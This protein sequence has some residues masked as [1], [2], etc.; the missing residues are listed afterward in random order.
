MHCIV[1]H[2]I[3]FALHLQH[4][5]VGNAQAYAQTA[6]DGQFALAEGEQS[7]WHKL[8]QNV[9]GLCTCVFTHHSA[10]WCTHTSTQLCPHTPWCG[11]A[12]ALQAS[13]KVRSTPF[14]AGGLKLGASQLGCCSLVFAALGSTLL[15]ARKLLQCFFEEASGRQGAPELSCRIQI[16]LFSFTKNSLIFGW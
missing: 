14:R 10:Q 6:V 11:L 1:L 2:C 4:P 5:I 15:F 9:V 3:A 7:R 12:C 16:L 13:F 8:R